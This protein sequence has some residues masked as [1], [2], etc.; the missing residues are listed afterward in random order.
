M[1][2]KQTTSL[3]LSSVVN[4]HNVD[5]FDKES[6]DFTRSEIA[7]ARQNK[8][9][10]KRRLRQAEGYC[11]CRLRYKFN[12]LKSGFESVD[13]DS[14]KYDRGDGNNREHIVLL[15]PMK[16]NVSVS[17]EHPSIEHEKW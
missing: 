16:K 11:P 9:C 2:T 8:P 6:I 17:G 12:R 1:C 7:V 13:N 10:N 3:I 5:F 14:F 15:V 4:K